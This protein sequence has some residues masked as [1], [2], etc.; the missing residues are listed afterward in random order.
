MPRCERSWWDALLDGKLHHLEVGNTPYGSMASLRSAAYRE[1][2]ERGLR[3][4]T[5]IK[6]RTR[7]VAIQVVTPTP[8]LAE[9]E[10]QDRIEE[11]LYCSCGIG[12]ATGDQRHDPSC[13][14][15][16]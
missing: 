4:R 13:K 1:A 3:V 7:V 12:N 6:P 14:V 15:W 10:D 2:S 8:V 5:W 11:R 16:G 9:P